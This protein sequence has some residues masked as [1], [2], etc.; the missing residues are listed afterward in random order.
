VRGYQSPLEGE[1]GTGKSLIMDAERD[2]FR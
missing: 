1:L 2:L